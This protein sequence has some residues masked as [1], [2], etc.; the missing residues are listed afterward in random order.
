MYAKRPGLQTCHKNATQA[1]IS[2]VRDPM[3]HYKAAPTVY[4]VMNIGSTNPWIKSMAAKEQQLRKHKHIGGC[5]RTS[6]S[7]DTSIHELIYLFQAPNLV[8][9]ITVCIATYNLYME[10]ET[11]HQH[12]KSD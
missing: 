12:T 9:T 2:E 8:I 4:P 1:E 6:N 3:R 11:L 5:K 10:I 7:E